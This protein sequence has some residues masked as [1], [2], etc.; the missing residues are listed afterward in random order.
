MHEDSSAAA[1]LWTSGDAYERYVG[2]WSRPVATRFLGWLAVHPEA[3]WLDV[4]CGTGA[5]T[6]TIL[7]TQAPASV[8]SLDPSE[9]FVDF[10]R[11]RVDDPRTEFL[12]GNAENLP[13]E[14]TGVDA[15][16]SGLVLNFVA[17]PQKAA[18][19][20]R[21]VLRA[22][23]VAGAYIWDYA[24]GMQMM[25]HFWDAAIALD[26]SAE[27]FDE[28]RIFSVRDPASMSKLWTD[29]GFRDVETQAI[30]VETVFDGFDDYWAPFLAGRA[31]APAY[32][33]SLT[34]DRRAQLR[35]YLRERLVPDQDGLIRLVARA[36][37]VKG[38]A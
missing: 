10:A 33:M 4:G 3:R 23:G 31:P 32:A 12:V 16:V 29:A 7:A 35:E 5:L 1:D 25:R 37:A 27:A 38:T 13:A 17:D 21:R 11:T 20:F 28:A 22:D 14:L 19:E 2:R 30:E 8:T 18:R 6:Q 9:A 24:G 15:V 36:W 26:A 34:E